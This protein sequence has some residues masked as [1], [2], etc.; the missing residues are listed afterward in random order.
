LCP[1]PEVLPL[2]DDGPRPRLILLLY[3]PGLSDNELR[4]EA[5]LAWRNGRR[6][7]AREFLVCIERK[8]AV[9]GGNRGG[10][11]VKAWVGNISKCHFD[12]R[13]Y[14]NHVI[15]RSNPC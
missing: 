12:F 9:S 11:F 3:A 6:H 4:I 5:F 7:G 2:P 15:Y 13:G 10:M 1:R 14:L 8:C